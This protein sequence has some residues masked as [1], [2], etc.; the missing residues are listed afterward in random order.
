MFSLKGRKSA[1]VGVRAALLAGATIA[2]VGLGTAGS[3]SASFTPLCSGAK[4]IVGIGSSLQNVAQTSVWAPKF[5]TAI[6]PSLEPTVKYESVGSGAG[7]ETWDKGSINTAKDFIGTDD[8]PT[9]TQIES[10]TKAAPGATS[11]LTIPVTQTSIAI[12]ANPPKGCHIK[13][14]TNKDLENSFNGSVQKWSQLTPLVE[15]PNPVC[16]HKMTRVVRFDGSGTT[17]QFKNYL[18]QLNKK[19]VPCTEEK[20][21]QELEPNGTGGKPNITWPEDEG[22]AVPRSEVTTAGVKGGGALV[23]KVIATEGG[24]GYA[25]LPDAEAKIAKCKEEEEV[26]SIEGACKN[27]EILKVQNNGK[28]K[29]EE[30]TYVSPASGEQANCATTKYK[31]PTAAQPSKTHTALNVDWSQVFGA[32]IDTT[33]SGGGYP[34][35]TLTYDLAFSDYSNAGFAEEGV[36]TTVKD[37]LTGYLTASTGQADIA[38]HYYDA[39]PKGALANN[40]LEAAEFTASKIGF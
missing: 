9:T 32:A 3:A 35:C 25:A 28:K 15:T 10:I 1:R 27:I 38:S 17:Y 4:E 7:L 2:V 23:E 26:K 20:T 30:A 11:V 5:K 21:W 12:V 14:I 39:L 6:C 8:A 33:K 19:P 29:L 18:F 36:E 31:V 37:Y 13:T 34:L 16:N 40:V 22:C 24:I